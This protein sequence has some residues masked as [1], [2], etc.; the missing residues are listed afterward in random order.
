[1]YNVQDYS[2]LCSS[3]FCPVT[4]ENW[5]FTCTWKALAGPHHFTTY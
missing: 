3:V 2:V 1:M 5:H 4:C